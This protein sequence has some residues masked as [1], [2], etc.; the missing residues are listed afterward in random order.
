MFNVLLALESL[1]HAIY[2]VVCC[3]WIS[4]KFDILH[5]FPSSYCLSAELNPLW[6]LLKSISAS[7]EKIEFALSK[8]LSSNSYFWLWW[9]PNVESPI[10]F[11]GLKFKHSRCKKYGMCKGCELDRGTHI[12]YWKI[13]IKRGKLC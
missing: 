3:I 11:N 13:Y 8:I 4:N 10:T 6:I 7:V 2:L 12:N 9:S 1:S 5:Y